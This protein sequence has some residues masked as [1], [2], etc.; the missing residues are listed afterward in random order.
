MPRVRD[1]EVIPESKVL[2]TS[3]FIPKYM[4]RTLTLDVLLPVLY[5]KGIF[6]GDFSDALAPMLGE[7]A[8]AI[9]PSVVSRLKD[10]WYTD[11]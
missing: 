9:S 7:Q 6:T 4:R 10:A 2:F 5:L 1:R 8:K 3:Q 11:Y